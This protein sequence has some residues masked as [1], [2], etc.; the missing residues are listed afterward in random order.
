MK[1][2]LATIPFLWLRG[3]SARA[4]VHCCAA[5]LQS[6]GGGTRTHTTLRPPDFKSG[7]TC[8]GMLLSPAKSPYLR[9]FPSLAYSILQDAAPSVVSRCRQDVARHEGVY[10][11][12]AR[13]PLMVCCG[14]AF[15]VAQ[16]PKILFQP[17]PKPRSRLRH[18]YIAFTDSCSIN[19]VARL[20]APDHQL[21]EMGTSRASAS[22]SRRVGSRTW[23]YR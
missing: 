10:V 14:T 18:D 1:I 3:G 21:H 4:M 22:Q 19:E 2:A 8:C 7:K 17:T 16:L 6:R 5:D 15:L 23:S 9:S 12:C 20:E 11:I 13:R